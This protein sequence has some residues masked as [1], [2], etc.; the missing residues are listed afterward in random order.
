[1]IEQP[2][3]ASAIS[4]TEKGARKRW[5]KAPDQGWTTGMAIDAK[6][7]RARWRYW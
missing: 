4:A 5:R 3:A 2:E 1:L 7:S 6:Y